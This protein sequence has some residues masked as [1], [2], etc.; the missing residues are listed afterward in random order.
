VAAHQSPKS[1]RTT[2]HKIDNP[3]AEV[4]MADEKKIN[5]DFDWN[6]D[7]SF[8]LKQPKEDQ[9]I[10]FGPDLSWPLMT[11]PGPQEFRQREKVGNISGIYEKAA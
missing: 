5:H 4:N 2:T 8:F 3:E 6:R 10:T 7:P 1:A 9:Q 11:Q